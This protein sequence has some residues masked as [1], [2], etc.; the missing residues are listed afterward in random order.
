MD[1]M[2]LFKKNDKAVS[3]LI[4]VILMVAVTVI[5]AAAIGS[6]VFNQGITQSVSK[7]N[8]DVKAA[9]IESGAAYITLE[10][11]AG[12][13]LNFEDSKAKLTAS[14]KGANS[15][16]IYSADLGE[17]SAGDVKKVELLQK[18]ETKTPVNVSKGDA[19]N[20]KIT[21]TETNQVVCD[22]D[23]KF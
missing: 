5:L 19:V 17:F 3:P 13:K 2:N 21:D 6:S 15:I 23:I 10:H 16:E 22:K 14:V 8:I 4:G 9:G 7:E 11:L 18:I 20:I 1:F 12:D